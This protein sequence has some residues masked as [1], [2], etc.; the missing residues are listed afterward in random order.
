MAGLEHPELFAWVGGMSAGLPRN[1]DWDKLPPGVDTAKANLRLLWIACG[2]DDRLI[3][4]NRAFVAWATK[5]GLPVKAVETPGAHTFIVWRNDLLA[6][7]P[8][9]FRK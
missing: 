5:K 4:P 2:T 3:T 8:L 7:A 1:A 6:L 9:L